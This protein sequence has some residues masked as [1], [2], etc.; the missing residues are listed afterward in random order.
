MSVFGQQTKTPEQVAS[1]VAASNDKPAPLGPADQKPAVSGQPAIRLG[2]TLVFKGDLSATE[3]LLLLGTVEGS[4]ECT[5]SLTIGVGGRVVGDI[6]GRNI[7]I[8]GTVLGDISASDSVVLILGAVVTG[9]VAAPRITVVEGAEL[10]G[11]VRMTKAA[12]EV[13]MDAPP[14]DSQSDTPL[15]SKAV[16][17]LLGVLNQ[18]MKS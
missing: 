7:T 5:E 10:N 1:P 9:E 11:I 6:R 15:S 14:V 17:Q 16:E 2:K 8:K 3:E 18:R 12:E 4:L 13:S